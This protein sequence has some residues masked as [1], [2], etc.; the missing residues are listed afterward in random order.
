MNRN[1]PDLDG[2]LRLSSY[3]H[4]GHIG[5]HTVALAVHKSGAPP[6][7][8]SAFLEE[9]IVRREVAHNLCVSTRTMKP[10]TPA[11]RG[12]IARCAFMRTTTENTFTLK[13]NWRTRKLTIRSETQPRSRWC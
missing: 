9:L 2:T 10:F 3:L 13:R 6:Q 1:Q 8:R 4:F 11:S 5:P 7:D 12:L